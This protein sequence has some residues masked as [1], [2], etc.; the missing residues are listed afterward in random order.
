M[1]IVKPWPCP[2]FF[3]IPTLSLYKTLHK[4]YLSGSIL[5]CILDPSH[6][7]LALTRNKMLPE[8]IGLSPTT[9]HLL[10]S[11]ISPLPALPKQ[12]KPPP[13]P[14]AKTGVYR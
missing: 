9:L 14:P 5:C 4:R 13:S 2:G 8:T 10:H 11:E 7:T 6:E 1:P 3:I 12:N